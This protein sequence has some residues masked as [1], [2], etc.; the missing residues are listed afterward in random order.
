MKAVKFKGSNV[1]LAEHQDQY[2]TLHALKFEDGVFITCWKPSF[3]DRAQLLF[4]GR[5]WMATHT[6]NQTF[7][8]VT[9]LTQQEF[10]ILP[11]LPKPKRMLI[12]QHNRW[13]YIN[14]R[15]TLMHDIVE[16]KLAVCHFRRECHRELLKLFKL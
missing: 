6:F 16:L 13:M 12:S 11:I 10:F 5:L 7:Q 1:A 4:G 3:K 15:D 14:T 2:K 8:P 9:L